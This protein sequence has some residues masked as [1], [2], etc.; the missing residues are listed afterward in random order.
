MAIGS[1]VTAYFLLTHLNMA[2]HYLIGLAIYLVV[3]GGVVW[4]LLADKPS[5]WCRSAAQP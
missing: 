5:N 4:L 1:L 2:G 3:Y